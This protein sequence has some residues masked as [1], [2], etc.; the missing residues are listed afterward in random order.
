MRALSLAV[1][2][3]LVGAAIAA[4]PLP[5]QDPQSPV[6]RSGT[7]VVSLFATA[8][9]NG[10]LV[11]DLVKDDFE[12]LDNGKPQTLTVFSNEVLPI[13]VVV[14]LDTSGSMTGNMDTLKGGAEQFFL[15][16]LKGDRAR[17]GAFNDKVQFVSPL[18]G[19]RDTLIE[20]I[21]QVDFGY[22]T[23][24][25]D[26]IGMSLDELKGIEGR[27]IVLVFT[28]GNDT[29]SRMRFGTV[30]DRA[31]TEEV[32]VYAIGLQSETVVN[33]MRSRSR[34]DRSL[35]TLAERTGGGYFE[36]SR[37]DQ[38]TSTFT[39]V[40]QELH[41]QY[42]LGFSP[43]NRDGKTHKLEVRVKKPGMTVRARKSYV[44]S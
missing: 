37:A 16:L 7:K 18:T 44:A 17:L 12:V 42:L 31:E 19:N 36:L 3:A 27:R 41:S 23:R 24:L 21:Q 13:T 1:G 26:A 22:P 5:A 9:D 34:P 10:R 6:F 8:T 29:A 14:M 35:K 39:R 32:M 2:A 15:R 25:Y 38:M 33:G 20:S 40:A 43:E 28:D 11:P 30:L 4:A